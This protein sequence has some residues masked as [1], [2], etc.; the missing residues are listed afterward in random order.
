MNYKE[1]YNYLVYNDGRIYSLYRNRFLKQGT[2]RDGYKTVILSINGKAKHFAIHRLVG[3]LFVDNPYNKPQINHID[4][5][6]ANNLYS[7]L[8]WCTAYENNLHARINN[9]NNISES[10]ARRWKDPVFAE[11]TRKNM[12]KSCIEEERN[13]GEK[14]PMFKYI[15]FQN[16]KKI[17]MEELSK[18]LGYSISYTHALVKK[19]TEGQVH[20]SLLNN[21]ITIKTKK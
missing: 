7:N 9:L 16:N 19:Y 3:L 2:N 1:F 4:G 15:I 17:N 21:N 14:N 8:E 13:K 5:N 20:N 10:N 12:S 6:K 11:K 18:I